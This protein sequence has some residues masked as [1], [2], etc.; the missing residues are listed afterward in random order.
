MRVT[1]VTA[2][3][4]LA[5][6]LLAACSGSDSDAPQAAPPKTTAQATPAAP[7]AP[8]PWQR[9]RACVSSKDFTGKAVPFRPNGPNKFNEKWFD[10]G[11]EGVAEI[12][13]FASDDDALTRQVILPDGWKPDAR[14]KYDS[15][16]ASLVLCHTATATG[17]RRISTC[18]FTVLGPGKSPNTMPVVPATHH[19]EVYESRTGRL[20]TSFDL[21]GTDRRPA[22]AC[23]DH[24]YNVSRADVIAQAPFDKEV[25]DKLRPVQEGHAP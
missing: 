10:G 16:V 6:C 2:T 20:L 21:K 18:K 11:Y 22:A 12:P 13:K 23:P 25:V 24:A 1:A 3:T 17:T 15:A 8:Q 7:A 5:A 4:I 19:F 14:D 9:N